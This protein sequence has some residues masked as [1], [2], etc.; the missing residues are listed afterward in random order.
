[1]WQQIIA[2]VWAQFRIT[3]NH[4][5]RAGLGAII[6]WLLPV[7]WYGMFAGFACSLA[8]AIPNMPQ[9]ALR[10]WLPVGLLVLFLYWQTMPMVTLSSGWGLQLNK[11]QIYPIP[12]HALFGIETLLRITASPETIIVLLGA[13]VGLLRHPRVPAG[14]PL[15]L[16]LFI[17]FNLF[18]QLALRDFLTFAF[19]RSRFREVLT[20]LVISIGVLPQ[21]VLRTGLGRKVQPYFLLSAHG[22]FT[23]WQVTAVLSLGVVSG[24]NLI[25]M[26][27]WL[28]LTFAWARHQFQRG[29]L[30]EESFRGGGISRA[31]RKPDRASSPLLITRFFRDPMA[32]LLQKEFQSLVRMPRFR[33]VFG[34]ACVFGV[35]VFVPMT[36]GRGGASFI[37]NNFLPVVNLYGMLMLSDVLLLNIFGLDRGSAQLFFVAPVPFRAVLQAKNI[38]ALCMIALQNAAVLLFVLL[39][40]IPVNL[41]G[42]TSS[43]TVSAVVSV[44]LL[45]VGNLLSVS[46]PRAINPSST[47]RKQAGAKMQLWTLLCTAGMALLVAFPFLARW[48]FQTDWAFFAVLL[49]EFVIGLIVYRIALDSAVELGLRNREQ[50][51]DALSKG[52]SPVAA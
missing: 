25:V 35:A 1:M 16:L 2:I 20:I 52:L 46:S 5:P 47:M 33:V 51:V 19:N 13:M 49:L 40:R 9:D 34:M 37:R 18:V 30:Q 38:T 6:L 26:A 15:W 32:N 3:R 21:L 22:A 14:A 24:I 42:V 23:P 10:A 28:A 45:S 7:L 8:V 48:A 27:A 36:F 12:T 41:F 29:L 39:F 17:P 50:M 31:D 44:F 43:I 11:L 4:M